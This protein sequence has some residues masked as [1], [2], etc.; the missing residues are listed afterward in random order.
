MGVGGYPTNEIAVKTRYQMCTR[1]TRIL[2]GNHTRLIKVLTD[3]S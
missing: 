2:F 3:N 1:F